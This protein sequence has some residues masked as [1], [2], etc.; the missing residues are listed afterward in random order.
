MVIHTT[1]RKQSSKCRR[2]RSKAHCESSRPGKAIVAGCSMTYMPESDGQAQSRCQLARVLSGSQRP[3]GLE[4][5]SRHSLSRSPPLAAEL[6][7]RVWNR[8][9]VRREEKEKIEVVK[10]DWCNKERVLLSMAVGVWEE[11]NDS[12]MLMSKLLQHVHRRCVSGHKV[13]QGRRKCS[14][15]DLVFRVLC[16]PAMQCREADARNDSKQRGY[17]RET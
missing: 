7:A 5:A 15:Q 17:S 12:S 2:K 11:C 8:P 10:T 1:P 6:R 4:R 9:S 16:V 3:S 14:R 13:T